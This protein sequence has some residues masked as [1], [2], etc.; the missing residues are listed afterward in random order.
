MLKMQQLLCVGIFP[1]CTIMLFY[2]FIELVDL[3]DM[4]L[5]WT[6]VQDVR[7][8]P[9]L[10]VQYLSVYRPLRTGYSCCRSW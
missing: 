6:V 9:L 2:C 10:T 4:Y 7:M 3:A 1:F 5:I 8:H